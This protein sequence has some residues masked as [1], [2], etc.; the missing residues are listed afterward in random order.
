MQEVWKDVVGFESLYQVSN[1]GRVRVCDRVVQYSDGRV[2]NYKGKILNLFENKRRGYVYV[3]MRD[4][5]HNKQVYSVH[6]LVAQAFIPNPNNW[7]EVNHKDED[8]TNNCVENLEWCTRLYNIMYGTLP[9]RRSESAKKCTVGELN[10]MFGKKHSEESRRKM[11]EAA[12][13]RPKV[14][15]ESRRKMSISQKKRWD[16]L[17]GEV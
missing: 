16:R 15:D 5:N 6:R 3:N 7:P 2:Y 11:R 1:L 17:R 10:P 4:I 12:K 8:K 13:Y 14:S 9:Q